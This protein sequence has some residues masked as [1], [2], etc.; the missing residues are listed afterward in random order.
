MRSSTIP[1]I[2]TPAAT[3]SEINV[4]MSASSPCRRPPRD[5]G[6]FDSAIPKCR[7]VSES[8]A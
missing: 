3:L 7:N 6:A 8:T 2:S 1:T 5:H 4:A